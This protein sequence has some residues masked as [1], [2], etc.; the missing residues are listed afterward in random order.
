[1]RARVK[2]D[3][4]YPAMRACGGTMFNKTDWT[5]V[6]PEQ[7]KSAVVNADLEI[8]AE[9]PAAHK[10]IKSIKPEPTARATIKKAV[11]KK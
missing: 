10:F 11:V 1:M 6:P 8:E 5:E 4:I 2:A 7:E 9:E 3:Y